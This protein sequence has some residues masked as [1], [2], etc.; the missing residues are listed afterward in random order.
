MSNAFLQ[1]ADAMR[2]E[3]TRL[4]GL[5]EA[6]EELEKI[7]SL[8][9][10]HTESVGRLAS[11]R[12][13]TGKAETQLATL[14]AEIS[15]IEARANG[16]REDAQARAAAA[17][18]EAEQKA[19]GILDAA[20]KSADK[21]IVAA[22]AEA[23]RVIAAARLTSGEFFEQKRDAEARLIQLNSEIIAKNTEFAIL[24]KKLDDARTQAR[25]VM[26]G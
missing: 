26:E 3:V 6:A 24:S 7:G 5:S 11:I 20:R 19:A 8:E 22:K 13:E 25:K 10:A 9:Q 21:L 16:I 12:E 15:A 2:R 14:Q 18:S 17:I 23:D 4:K 1:A